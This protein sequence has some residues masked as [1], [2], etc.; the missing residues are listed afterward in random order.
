ML[1]EQS[2]IIVN[3]HI[4]L[5]IIL[6]AVSFPVALY[7]KTNLLPEPYRGLHPAP[8][9]QTIFLLIIIIWYFSLK[10]FSVYASFRTQSYYQ[11][12]W[13]VVKASAAAMAML[14]FAMYGLKIAYVSRLMIGIFFVLNLSL[15]LLTKGIVYAALSQ[16]R[17]NGFNFRNLLIVGGR[18]R[19][20]DVIKAVIDHMGA[21]YRIVGGISLD[22]NE[23]GKEI[24]GGI[25][26]IDT[27]DRLKSILV[28]Q[29][30]DEIIFALPLTLVKDVGKH[31]A[32]AEELGVSVRILP[33]WQMHQQVY[34]PT[35]ARVQIED[36]LNLPTIHLTTTP[37]DNV[38]FLAKIV[39]DYLGALFLS[40][41][42]LPF[43][44][45][46]AILIKLFSRGP[47]FFKQERCGLNGRK[48]TVYKFRTMA[49]D[50]EDR[51]DEL[52]NFNE[53]DGPVF[54]IKKDPRII[55]F[56]GTFLR[57]IGL[58]ELPQ[59]LNVF[60]GEMSLV[61]P[62]PPIPEEVEKYDFWQRRRLSMK[63]GITCLWQCTQ[64][65][66]DVCFH[67]WM[68]MDLQY[69][70]NWSLMLDFKILLKTAVVVLTGQGR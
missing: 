10:F 2:K 43:F 51:R 45:I 49:S 59:L 13:K 70:D 36:F 57:K 4:I 22:H 48:I 1:K 65:R 30:V 25:R 15:L 7:I 17:R 42:L 61:G 69:I 35:N 28:H 11:I 56:L 9:Y 58:D 12:A 67:D 6:I 31:I 40:I 63:P 34:K 32:T 47:I 14:S 26:Y 24:V 29:V 27:I 62:R 21:G 18:K 60:K 8:S 5:D 38:E 64:N 16:F 53:L 44:P 66:N 54:K 50:A 39:L 33:D 52:E 23:V 19:A 3:S 37:S 55:P 41:A 68:N 46:I 20:V